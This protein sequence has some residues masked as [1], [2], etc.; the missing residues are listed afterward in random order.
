[1]RSLWTSR[2]VLSDEKI[3]RGIIAH[4]AYAARFGL[5]D[6]RRGKTEMERDIQTSLKQRVP[7]DSFAGA[8]CVCAPEAANFEQRLASMT[9]QESL[10]VMVGD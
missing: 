6:A 9:R 2:A 1:M 10:I 3:F 8:W 7:L 4:V 5:T